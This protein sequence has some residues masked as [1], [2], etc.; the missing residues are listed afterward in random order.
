MGVSLI[1]HGHW[2]FDYQHT[3][4]L[5]LST[6]HRPVWSSLH[7]DMGVSRIDIWRRQ[8]D[9]RDEQLYITNKQLIINKEL[10]GE[11]VYL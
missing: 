9:K 8:I 6:L 3:A 5:E 10:C 4:S 11:Q 2:R 7:I 1:Q